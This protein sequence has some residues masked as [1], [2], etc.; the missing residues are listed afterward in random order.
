MAK[1]RTTANAV[2][3]SP[4][5]AARAKAAL[6]LML[7]SEKAKIED[8]IEQAEADLRAYAAESGET[9]IGPVVCYNRPTQPSMKA[10]VTGKAFERIKEE[11]LNLVPSHY[12]KRSLDVPSIAA[13]ITSDHGLSAIL[14]TKG[15]TIVP[16]EVKVY[17]KEAEA[18]AVSDN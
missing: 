12:V 7:R 15:V 2:Q 6:L 18:V 16:G 4:A 3:L 8:Q 17:F 10:A 1:A 11:L 5:E 14:T 9:V 13:A